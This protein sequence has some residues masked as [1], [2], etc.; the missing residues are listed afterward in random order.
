MRSKSQQAKSNSNS[1]RTTRPASKTTQ[2]EVSTSKLKKTA[3]GKQKLQTTRRKSTAPR[4]G[5]NSTFAIE[6]KIKLEA[7][8]TA[9]AKAGYEES[10]YTREQFKEEALRYIVMNEISNK[11]TWGK[12]PNYEKKSR[13]R[14]YFNLNYKPNK[15]GN[16]I[17]K[18]PDIGLCT[19][20]SKEKD[21]ES[22]DVAIELKIQFKKEEIKKDLDKVF[23]Y[24]NPNKGK[25]EYE[26]S[27]FIA[28]PK[29]PIN[30]K[31]F[32]NFLKRMDLIKKKHSEGLNKSSANIF[33]CWIDLQGS[34]DH[35][36]I[37]YMEWEK[38][39]ASIDRDLM[40]NTTK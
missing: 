33:F 26:F 35:F 36:W 16:S 27:A 18:Y 29:I 14:I 11:R 10:Q 28:V 5:L 24:I 34:L 21:I 8:L 4:V 2:K 22:Y 7:A 38:I 6:K 23:H 9:A 31:G 12:F 25:I 19:V 20:C 15:R 37:T 32:E 39:T 40:I 13:K 1:K 3:V 30:N 17:T